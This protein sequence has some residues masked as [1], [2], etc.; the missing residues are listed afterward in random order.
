MS[1]TWNLQRRIDG[2][3]THIPHFLAETNENVLEI[4]KYS[5]RSK[6]RW[7]QLYS[8]NLSP[9]SSL[10]VNDERNSPKEPKEGRARFQQDAERNHLDGTDLTSASFALVAGKAICWDICSFLFSTGEGN[11][12]IR[13]VPALLRPFSHVAMRTVLFCLRSTLL[14][15]LELAGCFPWPDLRRI[16]PTFCWTRSFAHEH[17]HGSAD[18]SSACESSSFFSMLLFGLRLHSSLFLWF[19]SCVLLSRLPQLWL[20]LQLCV[21]VGSVRNFCQQKKAA[22]SAQ[23]GPVV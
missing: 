6:R 15:L 16:Q 2:E 21:S 7:T 8:I 11:D 23:Y 10:R 9:A 4:D 22:I 12:G 3:P 18:R 13:S 1:N 5:T 19:F 14:K 17:L 20:L